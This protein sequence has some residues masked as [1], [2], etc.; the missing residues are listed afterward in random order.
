MSRQIKC[1][2]TYRGFREKCSLS[3]LCALE[4]YRYFLNE[5]T[6]QGRFIWNQLYDTSCTRGIRIN[7]VHLNNSLNFNV[8]CIKNYNQFYSIDSFVI[9][10]S[11]IL[12]YKQNTLLDFLVKNRL[13]NENFYKK[14]CVFSI[15]EGINIIIMR[16]IIILTRRNKCKNGK[17]N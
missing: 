6:L 11:W 9:W 14:I 12:C 2:F 5:C 3:Y 15:F 16:N 8:K 7:I 4:I 17:T 1:S 13:Y 10:N